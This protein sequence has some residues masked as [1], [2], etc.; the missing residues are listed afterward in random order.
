MVSYY[1]GFDKESHFSESLEGKN[2]DMEVPILVTP[3]S[4]RKYAPKCRQMQVVGL[5]L[6]F[7]A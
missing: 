5:V 3:R 4:L 1:M 6:R 2:C 7:W